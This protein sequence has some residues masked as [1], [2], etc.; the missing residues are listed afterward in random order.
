MCVHTYMIRIMCVISAKRTYIHTVCLSWC[1]STNG[2]SMHTHTASGVLH[3]IPCILPGW[4]DAHT[5]RSP[6]PA[7]DPV[8]ICS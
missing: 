5:E 6:F 4:Y 7:R 8:D 1:G 2:S 3:A